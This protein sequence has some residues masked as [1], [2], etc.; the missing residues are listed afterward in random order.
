M[1]QPKEARVK[2]FGQDPLDKGRTLAD[3]SKALQ[4]AGF[5]ESPV[6]PAA[7]PPPE[8]KEPSFPDPKQKTPEEMNEHPDDVMNTDNPE[9][10]PKPPGP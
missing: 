6:P 4:T 7:A 2:R 1:T 5:E 3:V 9:D 10:E 8:E